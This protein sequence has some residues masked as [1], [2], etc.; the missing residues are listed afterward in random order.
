MGRSPVSSFL[1]TLKISKLTKDDI[2]PVEL[3]IGFMWSYFDL[4]QTDR[5]AKT[6][7]EKYFDALTRMHGR[8]RQQMHDLNLDADEMWRLL[9]TRYDQYHQSHRSEGKIDY[10]FKKAAWEM[11]KNIHDGPNVLLEFELTLF[12]QQNILDIDKAIKNISLRDT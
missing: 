9:K 1:D 8:F 10:T 3:L 12:L 11:A 5:M 2:D 4:L 7:D 6:I